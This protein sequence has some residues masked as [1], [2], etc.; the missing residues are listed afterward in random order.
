MAFYSRRN[1]SPEISCLEL[2]QQLH[3]V[4]MDPGPFYLSVQPSTVLVS[5]SRM[6]MD[7]RELALTTIFQGG[8]KREDQDTTRVNLSGE[9]APLR[10]PGLP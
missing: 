3:E 1:T 8:K 2:V 4:I 10:Y 9:P 6:D 7:L 5:L